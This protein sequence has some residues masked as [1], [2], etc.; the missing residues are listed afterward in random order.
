MPQLTEDQVTAFE[1]GMK[2]METLKS[3]ILPLKGKL[4]AF[5]AEKFDDIQKDI[6]KAMEVSEQVKSVK[7]AQ[8]ENEKRQAAIE[9]KQKQLETA[10]N[11]PVVAVTEES[12]EKELSAKR[13]SLIN[14]FARR[15]VKQGYEEF[16]AQK[17]MPDIELKAL[18][19]NSD[20]NGGY[21][22]LPEFGGIFKTYAY[23]T[24]PLR[25]LASVMS[26]GTD[27]YEIITDNDQAGWNWVGETDPR[28]DTYTPK[29]G[30][31][32]IPVNEMEAMPNASQKMIDDASI[33]VENWLYNKVAEVFARGEATAFISGSGVNKP[34]GILS[35]AAGTGAQQVAQVPLKSASTF[36]YLG[37]LALQN[38]LK[39][40][41]QA[42]AT[43]LMQRSAMV[44]SL[45]IADTQ[46]RPIFNMNYD[47]NAGGEG[48]IM[49]KPVRF[50][51][52]MPAVGAN[53]LAVA[54]GDWK[55]AYQIVD[56][57][58]MM[59]LR[60]PFTNKPFVRFYMTKRVGGA[61][62]N[63]E[64]YALGKVSLT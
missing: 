24:S 14:E 22:V 21:L 23:E 19:V 20:I 2:A 28:P 31:I 34:L 9:E 55:K 40:P 58:G 6:T 7:A 16:L 5:D 29:L 56:R 60:D 12:K 51:A 44:D 13:T 46:N 1:G 8:E 4:D 59:L 53:S 49:G 26:I 38:S 39:E 63:Y 64:A 54:Y 18:T 27:T 37:L 50:A 36:T 48:Y 61:V 3:E 15:N 33:D 52:D 30:K 45:S 42:N 11:R 25:Q 62:I 57:M 17:A 41:Y 10:L 32:A 35:I 43:F 47:R